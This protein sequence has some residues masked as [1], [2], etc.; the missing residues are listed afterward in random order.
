MARKKRDNKKRKQ[1]LCRKKLPNRNR[2][3]CRIRKHNKK[4][5]CSTKP[6]R[7]NRKKN[8]TETIKSMT[9]ISFETTTT[10]EETLD[11]RI[12]Q[13]YLSER[14]YTIIYTITL[15]FLSSL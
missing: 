9:T 15:S 3:P 2:K 7:Q 14:F 6:C 11:P 12:T 4:L 5:S 1:K 10:T 13:N 8:K